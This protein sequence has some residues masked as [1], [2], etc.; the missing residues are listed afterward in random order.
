[1]KRVIST[2]FIATFTLFAAPALAAEAPMTVEG[3]VTVDVAKAEEL[4][5][6]DAVVFVDPRKKSDFDRAH[7]P[8]AV[9]LDIKGKSTNMTEASLSEAVG[10]D[11]TTKIVFYCNGPS[12]P[13]S[14]NS[15]VKAK[16]WG[17]SNLFYFRDGIP[18]WEAAGLPVE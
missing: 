14:A 8:G 17:F 10:G 4:F 13:R 1:M 7:I 9:H 15:C 3:A 16:A 11:K 18:A 6:D 12:C 5:N 2:L